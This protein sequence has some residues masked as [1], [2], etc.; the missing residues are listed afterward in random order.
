MER[1][2]SLGRRSSLS[3]REFAE[4]DWVESYLVLESRGQFV[5]FDLHVDEEEPIVPEGKILCRWRQRIRPHGKEDE[6][7]RKRSALKHAET[8]FI[9]LSEEE[10]SDDPGVR[11]QQEALRYFLSLYLERKRI[12][13]GQGSGRVYHIKEKKVYS[14]RP[15]PM[16]PELLDKL[17]AVVE[18]L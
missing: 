3:G 15:I 9:E 11:S 8:L 5:R 16:G 1:L 14:V 10:L 2:E 6:Q 4:G 17:G 12:L 7:E 18:A 13:R